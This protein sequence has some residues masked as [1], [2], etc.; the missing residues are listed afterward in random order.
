LSPVNGP[1]LGGHYDRA[2]KPLRIGAHQ[3][4]SKRRQ[5]TALWCRLVISTNSPGAARLRASPP[6][7]AGRTPN[8][9]ASRDG[10]GREP[11][12]AGAMIRHRADR[13]ERSD[14]HGWRH[15]VH[16]STRLGQAVHKRCI[17]KSE[18]RSVDRPILRNS[19]V[20]SECLDPSPKVPH[21]DARTAGDSR[22]CVV[23]NGRGRST[24]CERRVH[25]R[26]RGAFRPAECALWQTRATPRQV[27]VT[28]APD[29]ASMTQVWP[30]RSR[31]REPSGVS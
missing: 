28:A 20:R 18:D 13:R 3:P 12:Y 4:R 11:D 27:V 19:F 26:C 10:T 1:L 16:G 8:R 6:D 25:C 31:M 17:A 14:D 30:R 22:R 15:P 9:A 7:R 24:P 2:K 5:A 23:A 21:D 29:G